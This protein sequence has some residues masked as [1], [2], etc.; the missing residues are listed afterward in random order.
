MPSAA[1]ASAI[2][3]PILRPDPVIN[4]FF[5]TALTGFSCCHHSNPLLMCFAVARYLL[6]G[7]YSA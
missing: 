4:A 6:F 7:G 3:L 2:A 1:K 5:L